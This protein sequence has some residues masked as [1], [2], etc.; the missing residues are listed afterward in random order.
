M[1]GVYGLAHEVLREVPPLHLERDELTRVQLGGWGPDA[2]KASAYHD[3]AVLLYDFAI[4]GA[5][6]TFVGLLLH[7]L[8]HAHERALLADQR[9]ALRRAYQSIA[10]A[11]ALFGA[12]F[13]LDPEAR[14]GYQR[15]AFE[16][17]VSDLY[18][19]Y[20]A[21]GGALRRFASQAPPGARGSWGEAYGVMMETFDG[22]EYE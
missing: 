10:A 19:A 11:D 20:A 9:L 16:E 3:G 4:R 21:C 17:F 6:R 13:L 7:E 1:G 2:A 5:R 12:E 8:G 14:R 15:L 22:W 18:L